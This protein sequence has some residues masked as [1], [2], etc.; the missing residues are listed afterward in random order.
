WAYH[1][2]TAG[3]IKSLDFFHCPSEPVIPT[4]FNRESGIS[5]GYNI[6]TF[7][8]NPLPAAGPSRFVPVVKK[9]AEIQRSKKAPS[10]LL[11]GD[12]APQG[13][14]PGSTLPNRGGT[15]YATEFYFWYTTDRPVTQAKYDSRAIYLR[16]SNKAGN[17]V[18]LS[19]SAHAYMDSGPCYQND[20]WFPMQKIRY[21]PADASLSDTW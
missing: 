3:Y 1:H 14:L 7:G 21:S 18:T 11:Y 15:L 8:Q 4:Y 19:G 16:H 6:M 2:F 9:I 5:Y 20:A 10:V 17:Y 12:G 13:T